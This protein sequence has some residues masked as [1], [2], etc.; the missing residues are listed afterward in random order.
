MSEGNEVLEYKVDKFEDKVDKFSYD[1]TEMKIDVTEMKGDIKQVNTKLDTSLDVFR[2][3]VA[4]DEKIISE[5]TPMLPLLS[6]MVQDH[7]YKKQK[8]QRRREF[9]E[10][11]KLHISFVLTVLALGS[12][13][14]GFF[15]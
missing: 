8:R 6:S 2:S 9:L 14:Y 5:L 15:G 3:H 1:L 10:T 13:I 11:W 4:G 12:A 7:D